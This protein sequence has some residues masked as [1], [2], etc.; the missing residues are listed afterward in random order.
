M[1]VEKWPGKKNRLLK[2]F[3]KK[4]EKYSCIV[5]DHLITVTKTCKEKLIERGNPSDKITII[6]NSANE[7]V[8]QFD[9]TRSFHKINKRLKLIYYG[10][11]AER[12]GLHIAIKAM[13]LVLEEIPESR[14]D[15]YGKIENGYETYLKGLILECNLENQIN[16]NGV[17]QRELIPNLLKSSDI[18]IVPHLK[19]DYSNLALPTK[20]FEYIASGIPVISTDLFD[21]VQTFGDKS[22][23]F[24]QGNRVQALAEKVK[25]NLRLSND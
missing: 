23:T 7:S 25:E 13:Q 12:F 16:L 8:F 6:F 14:L 3:I 4:T 22:I 2:Y 20:A 24:C 21:L 1:L 9:H 5:S 19:S 18:G 15:I 10:T 11:I 17:I